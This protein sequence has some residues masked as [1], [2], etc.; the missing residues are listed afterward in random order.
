MPLDIMPTARTVTATLHYLKRGTK[1]A[2]YVTEPRRL[3]SIPL[4]SLIRSLSG[5]RTDVS[6]TR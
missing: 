1:P 2:H 6:R 3:S 4:P 5:R